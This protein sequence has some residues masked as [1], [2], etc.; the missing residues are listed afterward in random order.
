MLL[1]PP[2]TCRWQVRLLGMNNGVGCSADFNRQSRRDDLNLAQDVSPGYPDASENS[3]V[4]T[5][6][7]FY[8]GLTS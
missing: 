8:A 6:K 2:S 3:P 4:G 5:A 7:S 1:I